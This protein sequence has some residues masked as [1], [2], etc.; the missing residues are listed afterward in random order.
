MAST[1]SP[2]TF[3][4]FSV[5]STFYNSQQI[6]ADVETNAATSYVLAHGLLVSEAQYI[7]E[8]GRQD[9]HDQ[10]RGLMFT[11]LVSIITK[12]ASERTAEE[13]DALQWLTCLVFAHEYAAYGVA[14]NNSKSFMSDACNYQQDD[15]VAQQL[16]KTPTPS[17]GCG[18]DV[19][20]S[21]TVILFPDEN[22]SFATSFPHTVLLVNGQPLLRLVEVSP[23]VIA[24]VMDIRDI[25]G[26][27]IVRFDN[28]GFVVGRRL[29][30]QRP[31]ASTLLVEDEF[32]E[33]ALMI[34]YLNPKAILLS[35]CMYFRGT[36]LEINLNPLAY[37][38]HNSMT[39]SCSGDGKTADVML[40]FRPLQ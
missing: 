4:Q 11:E 2:N 17:N 6:P 38:N 8:Y 9:L 12:P 35:G 40:N 36:K 13:A 33:Q 28:D 21:A 23:G 25:E 16:G 27:I 22:A 18:H 7:Y 15:Q 31:N 37:Q 26:K 30:V 29:A 10:I 5:S 3:I 24:P 39:H 34:N 19:P 1:P 32:G 14:L 20:Q